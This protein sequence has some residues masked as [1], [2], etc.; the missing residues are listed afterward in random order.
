MTG[1]PG[2]ARYKLRSDSKE[3]VVSYYE[4]GLNTSSSA[5]DTHF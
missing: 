3:I 1:Q 4:Q 5:S 2:A